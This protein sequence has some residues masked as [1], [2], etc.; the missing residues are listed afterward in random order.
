MES[1]LLENEPQWRLG[2]FLSVFTL[3]AL[4]ERVASRRRLNYTRVQRWPHNVLLTAFN[5]FLLRWLFPIAAVGWA[6]E[7]EARG[8]GLFN[9]LHL[10]STVEIILSIL[11]LDFA[12]Y[13]QHVMFHH[14]PVLWRLHRMH[15]TDL[16]YDVTTGARFHPIE[17]ILSMLIKMAV[18]TVLGPAAVAVLIFEI[19]LNATAMFNHGNIMLPVRIDRVLRLFVVTPDM[20]RVHH[21]VIPRETHSNFGFNMPWWDR[22]CG[23]YRA[24]PEAGH[25]GITIGLPYARDAKELRLD[26]LLVQP[27]RNLGEASASS[28]PDMDS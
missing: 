27:F 15:H 16:D 13:A 11:I 7:C 4:W 1:V 14:V 18:V 28:A 9:W 21:S 8:W 3:V 25:D 12:I 10:P 20:H 23:T 5:S 6:L 26:R 22:I 24:Q 17:I 19:L 2:F